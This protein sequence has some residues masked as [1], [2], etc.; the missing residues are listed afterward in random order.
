[1]ASGEVNVCGLF[2]SK[3]NGAPTWRKRWGDWLGG[4]AASVLH[5]RLAAAQFDEEFILF[6]GGSLPAS[7]M[8]NPTE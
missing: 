3:A 5:S 2:R 4:P 8:R 7:A 6:G 1:L